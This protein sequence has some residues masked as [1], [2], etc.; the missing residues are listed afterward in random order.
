MV[1]L[2]IT[3]LKSSPEMILL[4]IVFD[5]SLINFVQF[6]ILISSLLLVITL[7]KLWR[8]R[9]YII[10]TLIVNVLRISFIISCM[11][12][13][14]IQTLINLTDNMKR[15]VIGKKLELPV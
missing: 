10:I 12:H 5:F 9:K 14:T 7:A 4:Q 3:I 2:N 11:L 15:S 8:I 1:T 6:R 13:G